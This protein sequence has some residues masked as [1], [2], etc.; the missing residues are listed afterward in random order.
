M[1]QE[2][3]Q[4]EIWRASV[5]G[6][7]AQSLLSKSESSGTIVSIFS[8]TIYLL[9][10]SQ[11]LLWVSQEGLPAHR[12]CIQTR[13]SEG[14]LQPGMDFIVRDQKLILG[15]RIE[16]NL[17]NT[18]LWD[19]PTICFKLIPPISVTNAIYRNLIAE[20]TTTSTGEG[21]G[22]IIPL[23][24]SLSDLNV[25]PPRLSKNPFI[26]RSFNSITKIARA[27]L[28]RNI[29]EI[30]R[31]SEDLIGLGPGLTPSGDDFLGGLFFTLF[32]L[33]NSFPDEIKWDKKPIQ[34]FILKARSLTNQISYPILS[35]LA[36]GYG[37]EPLHDLI[38]AFLQ[39]NTGSQ[40]I[41]SIQQIIK[42]GHSSGWD[43]LAG[44]LTAMLMTEA[45]S[46]FE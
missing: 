32:Y 33:K 2:S 14:D 22:Q 39:V 1:F 5:I 43:M 41:N 45:R 44:A 4:C 35:D 7:L 40:L 21:L 9:S 12:R 28:S 29:T 18:K 20:I 6:R 27:C 17:S 31:E 8:N 24:P 34:D 15:Y 38:T 19:P 23:I 46:N 10:S 16:V 13:I 36:E 25:T 3:S 37:P 11:E 26:V 30:T 42:I